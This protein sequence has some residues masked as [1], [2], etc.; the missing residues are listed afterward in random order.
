MSKDK[1]NIGIL[2]DVSFRKFA[3]TKKNKKMVSMYA[4]HS[5]S[6]SSMHSGKTDL[7]ESSWVSEIKSLETKARDLRDEYTVPWFGETEDEG[8][9]KPK[10]VKKDGMR[11]LPAGCITSY[12]D[13]LASLRKKW[14]SAVDEFV[15]RWGE[16][17]EDSRE[18]LNGDFDPTKYPSAQ[19]IRSRFQMRTE[20]MP[21]PDNSRLPSYLQDGMDDMYDDRVKAAGTELR[22]R[23]ADKLKHLR[24][25][26]ANVG[27][28]SAGKF[29]TSNVTNVLEL[30]EL[31]PD[32]LIGDDPELVKAIEDAKR[33]LDGLDADAIKSSE[34]IA[35]DVRS[36]ASAIASS[37]I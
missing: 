37:L 28:E 14:E 18:R 19:H 9:G 35:Q 36:K 29:Y 31:L 11:L 34:I 16:I 23:L 12:Q 26:C 2:T 22:I 27:G 7:I 10:F 25:K 1:L 32:M 5:Q 33:M 15:N 21:M 6:D 17:I 13:K 8:D 3:P 20:F 24:D 4:S 30:C